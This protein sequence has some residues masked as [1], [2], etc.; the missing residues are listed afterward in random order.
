MINKVTRFLIMLFKGF[1]YLLGGIAIL[2]LLG[3]IFNLINPTIDFLNDK[4]GYKGEIIYKGEVVYT[5][6]GIGKSEVSQCASAQDES[7][8]SNMKEC[9]KQQDKLQVSKLLDKPFRVPH[10]IELV[11]WLRNQI[12]QKSSLS[13]DDEIHIKILGK[14]KPIEVELGDSSALEGDRTY[15]TGLIE[16][17]PGLTMAAVGILGRYNDD[18]D[19]P[20]FLQVIRRGNH[21]GGVIIS[22]LELSTNCSSHA[23][24][25]LAEAVITPLVKRIL[26][27]KRSHL[28]NERVV[29]CLYD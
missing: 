2:I 16:T 3:N 10:D 11:T 21:E 1:S 13:Q 25:A 22:L 4:Y 20:T 14:I 27:E 9:W 18:R 15:L 28:V 12:K 26:G 6:E 23:K 5:P 24:E 7:L 29:K 17:T 8:I 19:I